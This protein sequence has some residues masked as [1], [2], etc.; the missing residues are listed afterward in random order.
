MY[1]R[2]GFLWEFLTEIALLALERGHATEAAL[3]FGRADAAQ[4]W[5]DTS[6][7]PAAMQEREALLRRLQQ[8]FSAPEL[9]RLLA[10][11]A[12]LTDEDAAR[13]ALAR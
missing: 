6:P 2:Q 5:R 3:A 1:S 8:V 4:A 13:I 10:E 7:P 11:G 12:A 9:E